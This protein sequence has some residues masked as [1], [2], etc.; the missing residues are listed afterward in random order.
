MEPILLTLYLKQNILTSIWLRSDSIEVISPI[1]DA[2]G[3]KN[4][5]AQ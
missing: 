5:A 2:R 4:A 1:E 3:I